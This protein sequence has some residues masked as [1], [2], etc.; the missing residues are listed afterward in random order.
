MIGLPFWG[1]NRHRIIQQTKAEGDR[2]DAGL[3]AWDTRCRG[4]LVPVTS[5]LK[6]GG[7]VERIFGG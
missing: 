2:R 4:K 1:M 6:G 7:D 5:V 3:R